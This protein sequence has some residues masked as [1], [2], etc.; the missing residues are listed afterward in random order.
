MLAHKGIGAGDAATS[1]VEGLLQEVEVRTDLLLGA[2]N[3]ET[4]LQDVGLLKVQSAEVDL[5][6]GVPDKERVLGKIEAALNRIGQLQNKLGR[7]ESNG[8]DHLLGLNLSVSGLNS[9]RTQVD[10]SPYSLS[11]ASATV[12]NILI[13]IRTAVVAHGRASPEIVRL[14]LV[15]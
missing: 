5:D 8:Y 13:N 12:E 2:D 3:K 4:Q 9:A 11:A 1:D 15:A 14:V 10:D 7:V 6:L